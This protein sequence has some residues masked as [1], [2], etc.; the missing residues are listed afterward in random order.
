MGL[1][2]EG[3]CLL[4][5]L[6]KNLRKLATDHGTKA[7]FLVVAIFLAKLILRNK[8][9]AIKLIRTVGREENLLL[10]MQF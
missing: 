5:M 3:S 8:G 2:K 9:F 1:P 7:T 4:K 6:L 10:A